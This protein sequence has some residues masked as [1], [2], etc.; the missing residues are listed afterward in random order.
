VNNAKHASRPTRFFR[1]GWHRIA[2]FISATIFLGVYVIASAQELVLFALTGDG[3]ATVAIDQKEQKAWITDG[4]R[5]GEH[6]VREARIQGK[7]LLEYLSGEGVHRLAITC[8]HPHSD[9]MGGLEDLL[10]DRRILNF[11]SIVFVDSNVPKEK[12][13]Y[14]R[15]EE[16]W[17][18]ETLKPQVTHRSATGK[19]AFAADAMA[20]GNVRV[21]NFVYDSAKVGK[22]DH[23]QSVVMQ[24]RINGK[25][26]YTVVDF[27]DAS[28]KLINRWALANMN[29]KSTIQ[30]ADRANSGS[31]NQSVV[32]VY[33]HHGSRYNSIETL[34]KNRSALGLKDVVIT[35]NR[36]NRYRH[37]APEI[38]LGLVETLGPEHVFVTDSDIGENVRISDT[39]TNDGSDA[40]GHL[41]RLRAFA[42]AQRDRYNAKLRESQQKRDPDPAIAIDTHWNAVIDRREAARKKA[43]IEKFAWMMQE[44]VRTYDKIIDILNS[45]LVGRPWNPDQYRPRP[46]PPPEVYPDSPV[47]P[48]PTAP[49]GGGSTFLK[50]D[51]EARK[52]YTAEMIKEP[53]ITAE[54]R[55]LPPHFGGIVLG[56]LVRR[57][58]VVEKIEFTDP[59]NHAQDASRLVLIRLTIKDMGVVDFVDVTNSELWAAYN[60]VQPGAE[61]RALYRQDVLS[62][63]VVA[64]SLQDD[65][66]SVALNPALAGTSMG[67]NAIYADYVMIYASIQDKEL[68]PSAFREF[69]WGG[70]APDALQWFDEESIVH[71]IG[72]TVLVHPAKG[73]QGCLLR[74]RV[75]YRSKEPTR[76]GS[77]SESTANQ[78]PRWT[79]KFW[80]DAQTEAICNQYPPLISMDRFARIVAVLHWSLQSVHTLPDLPGWVKPAWRATRDFLPIYDDPYLVWRQ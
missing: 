79:G 62:P 57:G 54:I 63:G 44:S 25:Q 9:H 17:K 69:P 71:V 8:S 66:M 56:N 23:D 7:D 27:D 76:D 33:P 10:D 29:G 55:A 78:T 24:Y 39:G 73:A 51:D 74:M 41:E 15:F 61:L 21:S 70:F 59:E 14:E 68:L 40:Q 60:F 3:T 1:L 32:I 11:E 19:N 52:A 47:G 5:S 65:K 6:G 46:D 45:G 26:T 72:A 12:S 58:P 2:R 80:P 38:L 37:P 30:H 64:L 22:T 50:I 53:R 13:L 20:G 4:G 36:T 77:S 49:S 28:T 43:R 42:V 75:A 18:S 48:S 31:P 35:V 34:L 16:K 67:W